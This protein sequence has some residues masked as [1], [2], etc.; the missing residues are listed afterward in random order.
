[1]ALGFYGC[2]DQ[3][4]PATGRAVP[5]TVT[6]DTVTVL[7]WNVENFFDLTLDGNEYPEY[8][9]G[10]NGW[11]QFTYEVKLANVASV[12]AGANADVVGLCEIENA[13]TVAALAEELRRRGRDYPYTAVADKPNP[14]LTMP[15]LLSRFPIT[16]ST[17]IA[18]VRTDDNYDSRNIL[19]AEVAIA[20]DTLTIFVCHWPSKRHAESYRLATA[21]SLA[22]A[23]RQLPPGRDYLIV[24]DLNAD[25]NECEIVAT[26]GLD[27]A[28]GR[29]GVNHVLR[30]VSSSPTRF[31]DY[32]DQTELASCGPGCHYDLWLELA[33]NRRGSYAHRPRWTTPDH[34]LIPASLQDSTGLS[35]LDNSFAVYTRHDSLLS[36]GEPYAWQVRYKKK[37]LWHAGKGYSDHLPVSARFRRGAYESTGPAAIPPPP[38]AG[39]ISLESGPEGWLGEESSIQATRDTVR[40]RTG[41]YSLHVSGRAPNRGVTAARAVLPAWL[42]SGRSPSRL[43]LHLTGSASLSIRARVPGAKSWRYFNAP[44]FK[45]LKS[46]RYGE[47]SSTGWQKLSLDISGL[48]GPHDPLEVELRV[49]KKSSVELWIDDVGVE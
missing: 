15:S 22:V 3:K 4:P 28:G 10:S 45:P 41:A 25:Y 40:A 29:T 32:V 42:H 2:R 44:A 48:A 13:R 24:G 16:A 21:E 19:R 7:F 43:T 37:E 36:H 17:G 39:P 35:Y 49:Q 33:E 38:A 46:P 6:Q 30:T 34:M 9:P 12:L 14:T 20:A 26:A 27:D 31:V 8:R 11:D 47:W 23:L 18:T 5:A 1:V